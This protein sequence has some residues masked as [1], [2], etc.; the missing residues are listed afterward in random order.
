MEEVKEAIQRAKEAAQ[1]EMEN[2]MRED[3][4]TTEAEQKD[5]EINAE[6]EA[7]KSNEE[8]WDKVQEEEEAKEPKVENQFPIVSDDV[9]VK[10][11]FPKWTHMPEKSTKP[12]ERLQ[13]ISC[14]SIG[15][16][17]QMFDLLTALI[18]KRQYGGV[19]KT[20]SSGSEAVFLDAQRQ[21]A[22]RG[23]VGVPYPVPCSQRISTEMREGSPRKLNSEPTS[24]A[25]KGNVVVG[26][27]TQVATGHFHTS[28][29]SSIV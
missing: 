2:Q 4:E 15:P 14:D 18:I 21:R 26:M 27:N 5:A 19:W 9:P 13:C 12:L 20:Y 3:E 17:A 10:G 22:N 16:F 23:C 7:M 25:W 28:R 11:Q 6:A 8:H 1:K 29:R 24:T